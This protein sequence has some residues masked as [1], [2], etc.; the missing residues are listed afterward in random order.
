MF[1]PMNLSVRFG[2]AY[3]L[4]RM[5]LADGSMDK[6]EMKLVNGYLAK[7]GFKEIEIPRLILLLLK[8]MKEN[9]SREDLFAI[10]S[11]DQG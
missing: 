8:G 4:I 2:H 7:T 9:K 5:T 3:N 10:Y 6:N 11:K 1:L